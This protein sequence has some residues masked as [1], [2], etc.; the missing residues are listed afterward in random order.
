ME[1]SMPEATPLMAPHVEITYRD[2]AENVRF[3]KKQQWMTITY[4]IL[5]YVIFLKSRPGSLA[6]LILL[7]DGLVC[8]YASTFFRQ[9]SACMVVQNLLH[10]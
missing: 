7:V 9:D 3:Y 2:A 5:M 1:G 4:A 6:V 8:T 10:S